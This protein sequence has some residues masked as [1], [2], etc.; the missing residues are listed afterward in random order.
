MNELLETYSADTVAF[1][2]LLR[3]ALT[4]VLQNRDYGRLV[5]DLRQI[6]DN[7]TRG[8]VEKMA[9]QLRVVAVAAERLGHCAQ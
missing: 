6:D 4:P 2:S 9:N 1:Q 8:G 3:P 5:E 7:L